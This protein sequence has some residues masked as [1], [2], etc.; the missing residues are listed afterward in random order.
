MNLSIQV[1]VSE[2]GVI[3]REGDLPWHLSADL[4]RFKKLTMGHHLIM[5][6]KTFESIGRCLP[7]RTTVIISRNPEYSF[8]GALVTDSLEGALEIAKSDDQ[9]FVVGGAQIYELAMPVTKT[10]YLTR[11][12]ANIEGDAFFPLNQLRDHVWKLIET[13]GPFLDEAENLEYQFETYRRVDEK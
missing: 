11:V 5:G 10:L 7:G 8:E 3:G 1:A 6:R 2:N 12:S 9:P 4:K 13:G